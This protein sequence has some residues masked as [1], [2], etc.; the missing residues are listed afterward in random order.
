ML[1]KTVLFDKIFLSKLWQI[2]INQKSPLILKGSYKFRPY[3]SFITDI[4]LT[5]NVYFS[6]SLLS[7]INAILNN[8]KKTNDFI[9]IHLNCGVYQDFILPW[10]FDMTK[11]DYDPIKAKK[12]YE[13]FKE[14][15]LIPQEMY[16]K[17]ESLLFSEDMTIKNLI[18]IEKMLEPFSEIRWSQQEISKGVKS[19]SLGNTYNLLKLMS[20]NVTVM[21]YLYRA[22]DQ[23]N[24]VCSID[25]GLVAVGKIPFKTGYMYSYYLQDWYKIFKNYK[26][27]VDDDY[28][29]E[30]MEVMRKIDMINAL[31][32]RIKLYI[33]LETYN[34]LSPG[35]RQAIKTDIERN[36]AQINQEYL[37]LDMKEIYTILYNQI[38]ST[39][40]QYVISFKN[41]IKPQHRANF[42]LYYER[43]VIQGSQPSTQSTLLSRRSKG[44]TC[45]FFEIDIDTYEYL[46]KLAFRILFNPENFINCFVEASKSSGLSLEELTELK[47][48]NNTKYIVFEENKII[49][50]E[51]QQK[52]SS[53]NKFYTESVILS[54]Y[55]LNMLKKVQLNVLTDEPI[56]E[57]EKQ[58]SFSSFLDEADKA[59]IKKALERQLKEEE[60]LL[61][62][63][64]EDNEDVSLTVEPVVEN[65]KEILLREIELAKE[66]DKQRLL[67]IQKRRELE[68]KQEQEMME[69]QQE[70]LIKRRKEQEEKRQQAEL[71]K[72]K[73]REELLEKQKKEAEQKMKERQ[74]L[75]TKLPGQ[76]AWEDPTNLASKIVTSISESAF[77]PNETKGIRKLKRV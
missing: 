38:K 29:E 13:A 2:T 50:K 9:F 46:Y 64:D 32:N 23:G 62:S 56:K 6:D 40:Q 1:I 48:G 45:P 68:E 53:Y 22:E 73:E 67:A 70:E 10:S 61:D 63:E 28:K 30:Y 5:A 65:K 25:L 7:R 51:L 74:E 18:E 19:D 41:K 59:F 43:G 52:Q 4:D 75:I 20:E 47:L 11:C 49:L 31:C 54:E 55:P 12:W 3:G 39:V 17:I 21:R 76:D 27:V 60:T 57:E 33:K 44:F 8:I 34:I 14:K 66:K 26:W 77:K 35:Y 15:K 72:Q 24:D 42:N 37:K 36:V 71:R 16:T 58:S 69:R